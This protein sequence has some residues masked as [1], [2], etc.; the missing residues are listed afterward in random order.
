MTKPLNE[1][2]A[3][4]RRDCENQSV[5]SSLI[6]TEDLLKLCSASEVAQ[7]IL[8]NYITVIANNEQVSADEIKTDPVVKNWILVLK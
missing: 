2:I 1:I 5:V 7:D 6:Q 4:L 3:R 8:D